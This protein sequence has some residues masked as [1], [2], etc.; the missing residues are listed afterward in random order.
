MKKVSF[1]ET[2]PLQYYKNIRIKAD[3]GLHDQLAD[4]VQAALPKGARILDYGAGEGALSQRLHDMGYEIYSVDID[5][6]NFKAQTK[7]EK[8]NFNAPDDV[9]SFGKRHKNEFDLVLGIEVI[10]HV[11]N[12][13]QYLRDLKDLV[14]PHGY[15]LISTPNVTSWYSRV[16][17]FFTGRLHQFEDHD[18][19]YGHIN[20]IT[21]DELIL[22]CE[23]TG[24]VVDQI[25]PGGWLPRLWLSY[26][27]RVLFKNLFGFFSSFLMKG[28]FEGW[29]LIA[30]IRKPA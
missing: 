28:V 21:E 6:E 23:K 15:I 25:L 26:S 19:L 20:P 11:E 27:P 3:T 8:L 1:I 12:P 22:I 29:C 9:V 5:Q 18:H 14:K 30:L 4:I 16:M 7:F 17:F 10:E 13:W 2:K 24:L